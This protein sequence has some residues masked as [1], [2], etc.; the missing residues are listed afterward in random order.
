MSFLFHIKSLKA[1]M[2]WVKEDKQ[3]RQIVAKHA[4]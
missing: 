4:I 2:A 3:K 1:N